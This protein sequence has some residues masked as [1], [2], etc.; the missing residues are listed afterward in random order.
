[1]PLATITHILERSGAR[2][3]A[4]A[5]FSAPSYGL[6]LAA[7]DAAE[8]LDCPLAVAIEEK[9][10]LACGLDRLAIP[11][12]ALARSARVPVAVHLNHARRLESIVRA[13]DL[14]FTSVMFDG[15]ALPLEENLELS[16]RAAQLAH[17]DSVDLEAE[18]GELD[19]DFLAGLSDRSPED[20]A[21]RFVRETGADL[22]AFSVPAPAPGQA[23]ALDL[24]LVERLRA[25]CPPLVLHG[26]SR[27]GPEALGG[28]IAAGIRKI[29]VHTELHAV[30]RDSLARHLASPEEDFPAVLDRARAEAGDYV[31]SILELCG[32]H[33]RGAFP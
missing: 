32:F 29:N 7:I 5:C 9:A 13:L 30:Y 23:P 22:L 25:V 24:G 20:L 26:G 17:R 15:S 10:G 1:M 21:A 16:R 6:L 2:P 18:L 27:L 19:R 11:A 28:A 8:R 14:G 4:M 3:V 33:C 31:A 12:V